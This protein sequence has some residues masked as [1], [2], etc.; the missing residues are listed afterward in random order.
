MNPE[1][2]VSKSSLQD[3]SPTR[4]LASD[5]KR[6]IQKPNM[7]SLNQS[8]ESNSIISNLQD[9]LMQDPNILGDLYTLQNDPSVMGIIEDPEILMLIQNG[10]FVALANHPSIKKL[11]S[12]KSIQSIIKNAQP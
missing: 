5:P 8:G 10:D 12:N 2:S 4:N 6:L 9:K 7:P 3:P 11:E 1:K